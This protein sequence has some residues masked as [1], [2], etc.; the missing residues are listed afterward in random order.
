MTKVT[1][2]NFDSMTDSAIAAE[3]G[4][5]IEQM[6]LEKNLT[7][8]Q[9]ADEIG[10]SRLSYRK[11]VNGFGKFQNV[12]AVLRVFGRLDLVQGFVP[13]TTFSP[14]EQLKLK[15]KQRRRASASHS[16]KAKNL[17][18]DAADSELDW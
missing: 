10:L 11:L 5:R 18:S 16:N 9:L 3:I 8:Q 13:E 4:S 7:Q 12:I 17:R 14:I 1:T 15:G 2:M 6:R